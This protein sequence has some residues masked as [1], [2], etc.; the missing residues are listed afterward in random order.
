MACSSPAGSRAIPRW[1]LDPATGTAEHEAKI[2]DDL[3]AA[4]R[5]LADGLDGA[6]QFGVVGCARQGALRAVR[7][8]PGRDRLHRWDRQ[9][10]VAV[11]A[12]D[13]GPIVARAGDRHP[14]R[15]DTAAVARGLSVGR[16][17]ARARRDGTGISRLLF[18]PNDADGDLGEDTVLR[19]G[20]AQRRDALVLRLRYRTE[21]LDADC[22]ARVAGY[23]LTALELIAADLDA[24]H[25]RQSLLSAEE[26]HFQFEGLAGPRR[27]LPDRR[28]HE[29]FEAQV[30]AAS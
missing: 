8:A 26:I 9:R 2:P 4:L 24:E 14:P 7:R 29:L 1:S 25:R 11:P 27:E 6:A 22:A 23:H 18:D 16:A 10:T 12:Y 30:A 3:I 15:R 28:V 13:R 20:I 5:R 19:L 17:Q 21:V